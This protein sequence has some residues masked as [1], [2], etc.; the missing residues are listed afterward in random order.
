MNLDSI[1][2]RFTRRKYPT[3][4]SNG[5]RTFSVGF[6]KLEPDTGS[7]DIDVEEMYSKIV[8][9]TPH[10]NINFNDKKISKFIDD[11]ADEID[12]HVQQYL[13]CIANNQLLSKVNQELVSIVNKHHNAALLNKDIVS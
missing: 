5:P 11:L 1:V 9:D 7:L 10:C 13:F 12:D 2:R 3:G 8:A 6:V 4:F